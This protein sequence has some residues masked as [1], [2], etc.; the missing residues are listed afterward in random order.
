MS[1][2]RGNLR[3]RLKR[4]EVLYRVSNAIHTARAPQKILRLVLAEAV[5]I[6]RA[7]SGSLLLINP[8][9][10]LLVIEAAIGLSKK[11]KRIKLKLG[12]GVTGW[13]L[14]RCAFLLRP[15]A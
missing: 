8:H 3:E 6:T 12:Q 14:L 5:R 4:L 13:S 10:G 11:A 7:T 9:R 15:I 2:S 1:A